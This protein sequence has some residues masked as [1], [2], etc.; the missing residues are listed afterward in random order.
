MDKSWST[1]LENW[2]KTKM[3]SLTTPIQHS[4]GGPGQSNFWQEK[5]IKHIQIGRDEVKLSCL[6]T[7][8]SLSR[9]PHSLGP[10][11]PS[12]DK[13]LQ[14]CQETKSMYKNH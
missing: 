3:S 14:Q 13:Q 5:E 10:K 2:Q 9:K 4:I 8:D 7:H 12:A 6:Q 1:S 11:A